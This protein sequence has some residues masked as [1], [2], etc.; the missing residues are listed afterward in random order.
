M[1]V[2]YP[3]TYTKLIGVQLKTVNQ[4]TMAARCLNRDHILIHLF[5]GMDHVMKLAIT[6]MCVNLCRLLYSTS[7][8]TE[9]FYRPFKV[10]FLLIFLKWK[11][12][13]NRWLINLNHTNTG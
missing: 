9:R 7:G 1:D 6:H 4:L 5:Y 2:V 10:V 3:K 8:Y 11:P 13:T 12:F